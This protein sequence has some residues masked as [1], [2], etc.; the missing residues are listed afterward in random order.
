[1]CAFQNHYN[2]NVGDLISARF[3]YVLGGRSFFV[4]EKH[5]IFDSVSNNNN[6][7]KMIMYFSKKKALPV[8]TDSK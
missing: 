6:N 7:N 4:S 2:A 1:M 8:G 3:L 5:N